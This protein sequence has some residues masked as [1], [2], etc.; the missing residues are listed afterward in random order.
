MTHPIAD[1]ARAE[2]ARPVPP[3]KSMRVIEAWLERLCHLDLGMLDGRVLPR[4]EL[5]ALYTE[6]AGIIR[7]AFL[8]ASEGDRLGHLVESLRKR[9][10]YGQPARCDLAEWV[11]AAEAALAQP[12]APLDLDQAGLDPA[13]AR[14][15]RRLLDLAAADPELHRVH[16]PAPAEAIGQ[17]EAE[18]KLAMPPDLRSLYQ[19][20]DGFSLYRGQ[21]AVGIDGAEVRLVPLRELRPQ[22][23]IVGEPRRKSRA[24]TDLALAQSNERLCTFDLGNG[25]FISC[26]Q[27]KTGRTLWIDDGREEPAPL[28]FATVAE[29]LEHLLSPART[30]HGAWQADLL[31]GY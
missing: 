9:P 10:I 30:A 2:L 24:K 7:A 27:P 15:V 18:W 8:R 25:D 23:E 31:N 17:W 22:A 4:P 21:S 14:A 13:L 29:V 20:T 28:P 12:T 5:D 16:A 19:V 3:L 6:L 26:L 11:A 1:Q